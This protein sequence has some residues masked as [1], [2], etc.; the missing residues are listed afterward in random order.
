MIFNIL[1]Y[2]S[3]LIVS[4]LTISQIL[5]TKVMSKLNR[6]FNEKNDKYYEELIK[7]HDKNKKAKIKVKLNLL[8]KI[9]LKIEKANFKI[10]A[11]VNPITIIAISIFCFFLTY[12]II[13]NFLKMVCLSLII[14]MPAILI[15]IL[16]LD[17][18]GGYKANVMEKSIL[19]FLLQLKSYTKINNDIVYAMK[20]VRTVEPLQSYINTFLIQINSGIKFENAIEDLKEKINIEVFKNF[21][22]H[23]EHC[24]LYGGNFT[25]LLERSYKM[26]AEIQKE[27][28]NRIQETKSARLALFILIFLDLIV[29]IVN[30]K[31]A[32]ENFE[33]MKRTVL[34]N[35][36]LYWNFISL[37]LLVLLAN[38]VKK[39]DY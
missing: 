13:F 37:G 17:L 25:K 32:N 19:N 23:L 39:L 15:P 3:I 34:G 18:I 30:I 24:H 4:Y 29:Y 36:I 7:Y 27:K 5:N 9:N 12:I 20:E 14:S 16:I 26:I 11:I 38:R 6:Y 21:L 28:K 10:N 31:N 22:T 8:H 33:I 2:I 35:L 1:I